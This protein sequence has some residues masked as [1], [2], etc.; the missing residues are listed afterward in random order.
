MVKKKR[1]FEWSG[2]W[3]HECNSNMIYRT[4]ITKKILSDF[5]SLTH[6]VKCLMIRKIRTV[7]LNSTT[8]G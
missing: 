2:V 1:V 3:Y 5:I 7:V 8:V 4:K 6:S